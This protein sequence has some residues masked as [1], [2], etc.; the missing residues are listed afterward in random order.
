MKKSS[1]VLIVSLLFIVS[2]FIVAAYL[3]T[4]KKSVETLPVY[5]E[6]NVDQSEHTIKKFKFINQLGDTITD[7]NFDGKIYVSDFFF[8]KCQGI[9]PIMTKQMERVH[10]KYKEDNQ[11]MFLSHTV[12]PEEDSVSALLEYANLHHADPSKW[13]FVTGLKADLYDMARNAYLVTVSE[14]DGGPNDFVHTEMFT[15]IDTKKRIRG[16]YDGTDSIA[17][18]KLILDIAILKQE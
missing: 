15:L 7:R 8:A 18:N 14:G 12:K 2:A 16:F 10:A 1:I 9:C 11:I 3:I 6:L 17:V 13:H 4:T 5:G